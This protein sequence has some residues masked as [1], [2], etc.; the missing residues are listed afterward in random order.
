[1]DSG[2][3]KDREFV[4]LYDAACLIFPESNLDTERP[5][6]KRIRLVI[7]V[8]KPGLKGVNASTLYLAKA[9]MFNTIMADDKGVANS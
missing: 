4:T 2:V 3:D 8:T 1:M 7:Q 6:E 9:N 5:D